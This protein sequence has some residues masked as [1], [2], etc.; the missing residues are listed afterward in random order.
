MASLFPSTL[1]PPSLDLLFAWFHQRRIH[2]DSR[3]EVRTGLVDGVDQG[4][5][6]WAREEIEE[7]DMVCRIPKTSIF[8]HRTSTLRDTSTICPPALTPPTYL[9][10]LHLLHEIF[11]GESSPWFGYLQSLPRKK[12]PLAM[13]WQDHEGEDGRKAWDI[14]K[15]G[16]LEWRVR[17]DER[18]LGGNLEGSEWGGGGM[19]ALNMFFDKFILPSMAASP[20]LRNIKPF[21]AP[22][23]FDTFLH[24]YSLVS[25]RAFHVDD[26]HHVGLVTPA[27]LF[28]HSP[29]N[30]VHFQADEFVCEK[31]GSLLPCIH[32]GPKSSCFP[33]RL[34]H[35]QDLEE[36]DLLSL[37]GEEDSTDI[38]A[39]EHLS[40]G[41]EIF[42]SYGPN[43]SSF[44]L[45]CEYGFIPSDAMSLPQDKIHL[46]LSL[47]S[48]P[49]LPSPP[50]SSPSLSTSTS[51]YEHAFIEPLSTPDSFN[52]RLN[53]YHTLQEDLY[54]SP[55]A[56]LSRA[57]FERIAKKVFGEDQDGERKGWEALLRAAGGGKVGSEGGEKREGWEEWE[58]LSEEVVRV[59]EG[60]IEGLREREGL[61]DLLEDEQAGPLS[62]MAATLI[63]GER[64]TLEVCRARWTGE[65]EWEG[66]G[67][68]QDEEV[69]GMDQDM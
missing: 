33:V 25:S 37:F 65:S 34:E 42:N 16:E 38:V 41:E 30:N 35:L 45:A 40:P 58:R 66:E 56:H 9:L 51:H 8:T 50:S 4:W 1:P 54:V 21:P 44:R 27:D 46:P 60:K 47:L 3:L 39:N 64:V 61:W 68:E 22:P 48:L 59:L 43:L 32:D 12:I 62:K 53:P 15:G 14:V 13:F 28:N 2:F 67:E 49:P 6:V 26:Y 20:H 23:T 10:T 31:C 11:L 18:G 69:E 55:D 36:S 52:A 63:L 29:L 17:E 5:G 19:K 24:A 57:L 7:E